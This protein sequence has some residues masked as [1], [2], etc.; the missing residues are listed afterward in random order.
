MIQP[1]NQA[2]SIVG[3]AFNSDAKIQKSLRNFIIE[4]MIFILTTYGKINFLSLH[5][6]ASNAKAASDRTSKED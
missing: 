2:S 5:G 1:L 4:T 6:M 3:S